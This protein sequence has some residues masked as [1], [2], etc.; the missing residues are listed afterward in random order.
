MLV[1]KELFELAAVQAEYIAEDLAAD[2]EI[3]DRLFTIAQADPDTAKILAYGFMKMGITLGL[4]AA[5]GDSLAQYSWANIRKD[6]NLED[7]DS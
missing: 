1:D 4:A 2:E 7:R 5:S 3:A 6:I